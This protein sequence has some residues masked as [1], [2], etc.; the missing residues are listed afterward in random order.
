M[1]KLNGSYFYYLKKIY[2]L[3]CAKFVTSSYKSCS[4]S[5]KPLQNYPYPK[6]NSKNITKIP[7]LF[8]AFGFVSPSTE[9]KIFYEPDTQGK[10]THRIDEMNGN[11]VP[12]EVL[13]FTCKNMLDTILSKRSNLPKN[14]P[15]ISE[16][17]PLQRYV[18]PLAAGSLLR[19]T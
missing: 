16:K 4:E 12:S 13:Q 14:G 10:Q 3:V 17:R 6:T 2:F 11:S 1:T 5:K 18:R 7:I 8:P 9:K 15:H 19:S